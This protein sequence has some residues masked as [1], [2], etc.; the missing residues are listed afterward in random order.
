MSAPGHPYPLERYFP[1]LSVLRLSLLVHSSLIAE[2]ISIQ[3]NQNI[4]NRIVIEQRELET[5]PAKPG[6]QANY[7][8]FLNQSLLPG[9][10]SIKHNYRIWPLFSY[11]ILVKRIADFVSAVFVLSLFTPVIPII[12]LV[13]KLTSSGPVFFGHTREGLHGKKFKCWKFRTMIPGADQLQSALRNIN[14]VDGPQFKLES[15]PRINAVGR[16]LR[17]TCLDEIPQ[18]FNVILGQMSLVGPRPSPKQENSLCPPWRDARLSVRPGI[19]GLWQ[20]CRT[21]KPEQDFQEWVLYD[22]QYVK[23]LSLRK[24]LWISWKTIRFLAAK[25]FDQF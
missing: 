10:Q 16:F 1:G 8:Y 15:D 24:D 3:K 6:L 11:P 21:R 13:I 22:T 20:V 5:D 25:F 23:T 12:A 7:H 14:E 19:T 9:M 17:D 4:E 2:G 18:F